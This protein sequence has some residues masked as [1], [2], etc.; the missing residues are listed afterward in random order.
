MISTAW[1][2]DRSELRIGT[3]I[4]SRPWSSTTGVVRAIGRGNVGARSWPIG[5]A[6]RA[7]SKVAHDG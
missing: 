4:A 5:R 1:P 6:A 2:V 3:V 7:A